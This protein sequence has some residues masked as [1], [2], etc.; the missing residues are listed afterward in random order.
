MAG[1]FV[2]G[3]ATGSTALRRCQAVRYNLFEFRCAALKKDF[4]FYP[5]RNLKRQH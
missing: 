5:S 3:R 2:F 1:F 4:R